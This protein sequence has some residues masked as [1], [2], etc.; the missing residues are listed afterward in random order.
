MRGKVRSI[1]PLIEPRKY[2]LTGT[3]VS[4][5]P[6]NAYPILQIL[7]PEKLP[8]RAR[9]DKH[10]S[11]GVTN[12]TGGYSN[13]ADLKRL[14]EA[15][16][17]RRLKADIC[18]MPERVEIVRHCDPTS[19]Q[20][21][22]YAE[23]MKGIM[24]EIA[25]DPDWA[26]TLDIACVKLLR[27][28][29]VLNH[30]SILELDG[31]SGKYLELDGLLEEVLSNPDA[32]VVLWTEWN[33]AVDLLANRYRQYMV[34]TLDQRTS[35]AELA[36]LGRSFDTSNIRIIITTPSKGG[37]GIDFLAIARTSIYLERT[38][39]LVNHRQSIDRIVR[40]TGEGQDQISR[41]KRSPATIIYLHTPDSVDDVVE[42]VLHRKL[43]LGDALLTSDERLIADGKEHLINMLRER[44]RLMN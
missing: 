26:K 30:P 21:A 11:I 20:A 44:I 25:G 22:H 4:E 34:A 32:K 39:S 16:S 1:R 3:P 42:W 7:S 27:C 13:L 33:A 17:V 35:Q 15:V 43:N 18:G 37:T 5:S 19:T 28:R 29:Q 12:G 2:I 8:S 24:A 14:L 38:F 31:D 41:I 9:F 23:I 6:A 36:Q 10:F 40:R